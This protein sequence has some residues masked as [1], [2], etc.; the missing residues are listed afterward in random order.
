[1]ADIAKLERELEKQRA[2]ANK[3]EEDA[4]V[5]RNKYE[6]AREMIG[7]EFDLEPYDA[8]RYIDIDPEDL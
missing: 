3:A 1:M 7:I 2:R 6:H 8:Y 5:W 4:L